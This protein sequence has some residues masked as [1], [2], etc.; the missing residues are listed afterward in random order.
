MTKHIL[1]NFM[2]YETPHLAPQREATAWLAEYQNATDLKHYEKYTVKPEHIHT[3]A[4]YAKGVVGIPFEGEP[5]Y[6]LGS[7][8][9]P[10][11]SVRSQQAQEKI[12]EIFSYLYKKKSDVPDHLNHISCTHYQSPSAAQMLVSQNV[13]FRKTVV[14]HLYHMGC[15]A[16]LPAIRVAKSYLSDGASSVD[17]VHTELCSFH[18]DRTNFSAEQTI[19]NTLFADGAI[20]YSI[21]NDASFAASK[22]PGLEILSQHEEIL[23]NSENEMTWKLSENNFVM[24]LTK[25]VPVMLAK[26]VKKFMN[27]LADRAGIDFE[28]E[29]E[30]MIFAIHPGGPKIIDLVAKVLELRE[31][32][33]ESSRHILYTR[34]NMSSATIPHIWNH[35]LA[36]SSNSAGKK[37]AT[38][39]FG[40][41]LTI[42]GAMLNICRPS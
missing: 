13:E 32:Q 2:A 17:N 31:D 7:M 11:L 4:L 15:Y 6:R 23:P 41:G 42:T 38:V 24:R 20:K 16:A 18:L 40:P 14:T 25:K 29:K 35:I 27:R 28:R 30:N 33:I 21:K 1:T 19:M 5:L 12:L 26:E 36:D 3:R 34:G 39:A 9:Q 10:P 8:E 37:V 22:A